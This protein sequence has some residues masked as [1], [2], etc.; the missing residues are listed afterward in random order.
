MNTSSSYLNAPATELL[1]T[2]CAVCGRALVDAKS[3]ESGI[4]P[5]C[6]KKHGF[7]APV[8]E[9]QRIAANRAVYEIACDRNS[10]KVPALVVQIHNAGLTKL[11]RILTRRLG[12]VEVTHVDDCYVVKTVY[13]M[14]F[15]VQARDIGG[16][17]S[18]ADKSWKFQEGQRRDLWRV[19]KGT[20]HGK[21]LV[22]TRAAVL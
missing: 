18:A 7:E 22:G 12:G 10:A 21:P 4:G 5:E 9:E 19:L 13:N 1:A 14:N 20:F 17:W 15:V 8:S 11:S 2:E 3:V 6:R 16:R